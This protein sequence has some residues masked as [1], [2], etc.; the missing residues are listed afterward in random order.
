MALNKL[1]INNRVFGV[2][3]YDVNFDGLFFISI[4]D[5]FGKIILE[6]DWVM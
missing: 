1:G 3:A 5:N 4:K 2:N 6:V